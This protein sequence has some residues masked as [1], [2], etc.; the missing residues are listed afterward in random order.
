[1]RATNNA[2]YYQLP[3]NI[4]NQITVIIHDFKMKYIFV[5][6]TYVVCSAVSAIFIVLEY[7]FV[8]N[9]KKIVGPF[10]QVRTCMLTSWKFLSEG[11]GN[12]RELQRKI[13]L[14]LA[15]QA[16]LIWRELGKLGYS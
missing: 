2:Q 5:Y 7:Y 6:F 9:L 1:M 13:Y 15:L 11:D 8:L 3:A 16:A 12:K 14:T 4:Q 10:C